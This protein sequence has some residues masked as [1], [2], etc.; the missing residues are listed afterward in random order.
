MDKET[1]MLIRLTAQLLGDSKTI[2]EICLNFVDDED[3]RQTIQLT[4]SRINEL[5]VLVN[6]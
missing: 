6:S 5:E 2:M 3:L 4:L 1:L